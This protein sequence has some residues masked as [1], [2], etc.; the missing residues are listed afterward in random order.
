MSKSVLLLTKDTN[1]RVSYFKESVKGVFDVIDINNIDEAVKE[2]D[3]RQQEVVS[4]I[5]DNPSDIKDINSFISG[6]KKWNAFSYSVPIIVLTDKENESKNEDFLNKTV[7]GVIHQGESKKVIIQ[8]IN[9]SSEAINSASFQE[10]ADILKVLPSLIYLKD[11]KE[12]MSFPVR[13]GT[14]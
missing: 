6:I 1:P 12:D 9:R 11:S 3:E 4:I 10:F 8:R 2:L 7:I 13:T 5:V 14:T